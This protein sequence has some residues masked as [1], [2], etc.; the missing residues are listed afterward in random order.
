M[1]PEIEKDG[2][3]S[4]PICGMALE[5]QDV[6]QESQDSENLEYQEMLHRFWIGL[7]LS[8]PVFF[9][10]MGSMSV[11][12]NKWIAPWLSHW[13]QFALSTPVVLWAGC[14]LFE[15]AYQ[16]LLNH[17]LNMFSL[18]ALGIGTAYLYS[19]AALLIPGV[20]P[21]SFRYHGE[22]PIYFESAAVITV[23]VLLGQ[24]LESKARSKTSAAIKTLLDRAAKTAWM[25]QDGQETE[26]PIEKVQ[27]GNILR[28]KP[29]EK[30]PVDGKILQGSSSI[31]MSMLT[32][33][34][35]PVEKALGDSVSAG[36][37]NQTGSF[38]MRAEKVGN[39]TLLSQ[40]IHMVSEAQRSRAPIQGLADR[41]ASYFVPAVILI[42][43][44]TFLVWSWL[45][46][47]P[48]FVYALVN[49]VAV[50]IIACPC[51]LGL[52]TPMSMTV[53][54]GR[55]AEAGILIKDAEALENLEKVTTLVV[56]KTGTLTEGSPK[57]DKIIAVSPWTENEVL[58]LAASLEQNSEHPLA[59]ALVQKA[60]ERFLSLTKADQFQST[61]GGGVSGVVENRKIVVGKAP[62]LAEM[63]VNGI[64]P[65]QEIAQ[66]ELPHAQ[67]IIYAAIDN[68]AAGIM[69]LRDPIKASTPFA[70]DKLHLMGLKIIMLSGDNSQT[71]REIAQKLKIDEYYGEVEPQFKQEFIKKIKERGGLVAMA[72]DGINDAPALAAADV[73]IAM[74]SGTDAAMESASL[75]LVK[76]DLMGIVRAIHLSRKVMKNIRQNLFFAFIYNIAGIP[77]AAGIL[78]PFT[79]L[80][81]NPM[82]AALAMSLSSVSVI[83]NAL[84]LRK[85]NI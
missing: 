59:K 2:P 60:K 65:L 44:L 64:N 51:A 12:I 74:G 54:M 53:G 11:S 17:R 43:L 36:T 48:A 30:I 28:V 80:L 46:P 61:T 47:Q 16:S 7:A 62:F 77:I 49:S 57:L 41:V 84:R 70:I 68:Q 55:G 6:S 4:C 5:P 72:G 24:V 33:E 27:V 67:T 21:S 25:V 85:I 71:T 75:T 9:L 23:L 32:G 1:H 18:I 50:L 63:G 83:A 15:K 42:A 26:I 45:G 29:G 76:G 10:A 31:D 52:A 35:W 58:R 13:V 14:P 8:I 22:I 69:I 3:G 39:E 38:L 37:L 40:I 78:Y 79:G 73:G 56:D 81:L 82:I 34:S 20:F 66:S 19:V